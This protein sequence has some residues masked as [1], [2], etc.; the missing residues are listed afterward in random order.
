MS[1]KTYKITGMD[2]PSCAMYIQ[3][4]LEDAGVDAE[5]NYASQK[6]ILKNG[7]LSFSEVKKLVE[8]AGYKLIP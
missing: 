3:S 5:V 6:L 2:C 1:G 7:N 4:E 8:K